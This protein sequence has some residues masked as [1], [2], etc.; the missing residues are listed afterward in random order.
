MIVIDGFNDAILGQANAWVKNE[1][2]EK[3]VYDGWKMVDVLVKRDGMTADEAYEFI[4]YNVEGSYIGD[5]N[6]IIMWADDE[7]KDEIIEEAI[8][9]KDKKNGREFH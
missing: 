6:P 8:T 2:H 9:L 4:E 1:K 3:L 7:L 5:G